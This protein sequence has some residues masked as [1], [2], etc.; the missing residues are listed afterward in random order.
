MSSTHY[1]ASRKDQRDETNVLI[2]RSQAV[3][4]LNDALAD[5]ELAVS[6]DNI[7]A[8][9]N[10]AGHEVSTQSYCLMLGTSEA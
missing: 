5:P 3:L 1:A 7:A 4:A 8:V 6:D 10:L 9:I 2:H